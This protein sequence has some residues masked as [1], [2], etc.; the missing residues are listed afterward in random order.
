MWKPGWMAGLCFIC[1]IAGLAQRWQQVHAAVLPNPCPQFRCKNVYYYWDG[2]PKTNTQ[3]T[4]SGT[5]TPTL[6]GVDD[7]FTTL[8]TC[9]LP[10]VNAL[11]IDILTYTACV[12]PCGKDSNGV[13]QAPQEVSPS[14]KSL[15][16]QKDVSSFQ[17]TATSGG[18]GPQDNPPT[19]LNT[20]KNTPPGN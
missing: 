7:L 5:Q 14:G 17:C 16:G 11:P 4:L 6:G 2:N 18:P 19:N 8:S 20:N 15:P 3:F 12:P 13:W 10:H 9:T 1:G